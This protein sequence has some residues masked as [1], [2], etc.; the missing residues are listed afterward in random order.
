MLSS[1]QEIESFLKAIEEIFTGMDIRTAWPL[2]GAQI[3]SYFGVD[4]ALDIY[5]RLMKLKEKLSIK[6]IAQL[7]PSPDVIRLF[8]QHNAII[9]LKVA[10]KLGIG[11]VS[12]EDRVKYTLFLFDILKQKVK[13]DIFCLDGKN[14]LLGKEDLEKILEQTKWNRPAV[15]EQKRR[16]A[17]LTVTANNLCYTLFYDAF[18]A[19]GFYIH[20]PYDVSKKFG[21]S[22]M[23][24][25]RDYHDINPKDI[26][27]D[28]SLPYKKLRICAVYKNLDLRVTFANH[29]TS[30]TSIGDKIV[31]YKIYLDDKEIDVKKAEELIDLFQKISQQQ[32]KKV[33]ALSDLGKVRKGIEIAYYL[34]KKLRGDDWRPPKE[35]EQV[36]QKFGDK[37]IRR[38]QYKEKPDLEHWKKIYDPRSDYF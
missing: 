36:I 5:Y 16:I 23:L 33:N 1:D 24:V 31:A 7:M 37:F 30:T 26:W 10:K 8:L 13:N 18:M 19:G 27:P 14:L 17:F 3:D 35:I 29:P 21:D 20:G 12:T 38:F 6:E 9:G 15:A 11:N 32:T 25:I 4:E 34:F 22:A 28:L 2:N